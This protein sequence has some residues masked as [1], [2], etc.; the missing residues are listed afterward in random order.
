MALHRIGK[1]L[2]LPLA[3]EPKQEVEAAVSVSRVAVIAS[4]FH[5]MKPRM[6]I[7]EGEMVRRGDVLF[8]DRKHPGIFHTAPG[9]GTVIGV[10]RGARRAFQSVVIELNEREQAGNPS[11]EDFK[12]FESFTGKSAEDSSAEEVR[13]LLIESGL[14]TTLRARPFSQTPEA[15]GNPSSIFITA[16]DSNPHAPAVEIALAGREEDFAAGAVA[17]SKLSAGKTFLCRSPFTKVGQ[18][19]QGLSIE[20]FKGPHPSGLAGTHIHT[21]DPVNRGKVVWHIGYADVADI[22]ELLRTGR[23]G[24][25]RVVS[26]AGPVVKNPRLIRTRAGACID[27]LVAGELQ[28]GENRVLS[29]SVLSGI[30]SSGP[31]LGYLGRYAVQ[32][33]ALAEGREREFLG[34]MMPGA[35]KFSILPTYLYA[36]LGKKDKLSMTTATHGSHRAMVPIGQYERVFPL[37]ILPTFLLRSLEMRDV[38]TAEKLGLLELDEEDLALCTVVCPGKLEYG[39]LLRENLNII[40]A[41]G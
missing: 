24:L 9:A 8:E 5:G 19:V 23:L 1:G 2:D 27:E 16:M 14:W 39:L 20:E 36:L 32:I 35:N 30:E 15:D 38:E 41:E 7:M 34:W 18:G 28:D 21:L 26:L 4:D 3:G 13:A 12:P 31:V 10:N 11:D 33:S 22:G 17:L 40:E 29:G 6:E 25:V 37:D